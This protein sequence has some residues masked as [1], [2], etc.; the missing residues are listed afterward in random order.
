[1]VRT[2]SEGTTRYQHEVEIP[3]DDPD[4]LEDKSLARVY[5]Q[6]GLKGGMRWFFLARAV[7]VTVVRAWD[8][9]EYV[10]LT[11]QSTDQPEE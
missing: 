7:E 11:P 5:A 2:D 9:K 8:G 4:L 10:K 1:M 6:M 3:D